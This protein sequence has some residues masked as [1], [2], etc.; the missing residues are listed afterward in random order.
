MLFKINNKQLHFVA[1]NGE[2]RIYTVQINIIFIKF[3]IISEW[4][5]DGPTTTYSENFTFICF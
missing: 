2:T 1:R 3:P 5:T 4:Y